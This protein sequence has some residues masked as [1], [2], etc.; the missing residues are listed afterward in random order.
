MNNPDRPTGSSPLNTES[1]PPTNGRG[2]GIGTS[3]TE[4]CLPAN[5]ASQPAGGTGAGKPS[6][7]ETNASSLRTVA[8]LEAW[9]Q[10][11]SG[12]SLEWRTMVKA[13]GNERVAVCQSGN[14]ADAAPVVEWALRP[15]TPRQICEAITRLAAA[16][17]I[18]D[19]SAE[20]RELMVAEYAD[21]ISSAQV[22]LIALREAV[23]KLRTEL[24][25]FPA[26]AEILTAA[27]GPTLRLR[28]IRRA[29]GASRQPRLPR[30]RTTMRSHV[31]ARWPTPPGGYTDA[32]REA[33][34]QWMA[35]GFV[36]EPPQ[37]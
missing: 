14:P 28:A 7:C 18:G 10:P 20:G 5:E 32:D 1:M 24:T 25:F 6:T 27:Q 9:L 36:G 35:S 19:T 37:R 31:E 22:P 15:A 2:S 29:L 30:A 12:L 13:D 34:S 17:K 11:R 21:A 8:E 33:W 23:A 4:P 26:V 3:A 16:T